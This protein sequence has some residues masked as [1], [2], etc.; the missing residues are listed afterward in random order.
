MTAATH[1]HEEPPSLFYVCG[2][3]AGLL[4]E[5]P[6]VK[7]SAAPEISLGKHCEVHPPDR[8][9]M[10][11]TS[12]LEAPADVVSFLRPP[13]LEAPPGALEMIARSEDAAEQ[14]HE[15]ELNRH[16]NAG[17]F[18]RPPI[19]SAPELAPTPSLGALSLAEITLRLIVAW[20]APDKGATCDAITIGYAVDCARNILKAT[21]GY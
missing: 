8:G 9:T 1:P 6:A 3:C 2:D 12:I 11:A 16:R 21:G 10:Q 5:L 19:T 13:A 17:R 18:V 14:A 20:T 7:R 15:T 4:L